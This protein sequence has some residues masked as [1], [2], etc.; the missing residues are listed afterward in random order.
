MWLKRNNHSLRL[1]R[2]S[3]ALNGRFV[4]VRV[5]GS[6]LAPAL[7]FDVYSSLMA[8]MGQV[9]AQEPQLMQA[10]ASIT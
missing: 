8:P 7:F 5:R 2:F 9:P 6:P 4:V 1:L 3:L 10:P